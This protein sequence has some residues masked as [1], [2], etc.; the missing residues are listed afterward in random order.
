MAEKTKKFRLFDAVLTAVCV[1]LVVESSTPAAA[2]GNSQY[3]WWIVLLAAFFLP[4]GLVS[5]ELGTTYD[6]DGGIFDWVRRAFGNRWGSRIAWYYYINFS[7]WV[8]SLA[9]LFTDVITQISGYEMSVWVYLPI[10]LLFIWGVV[11]ISNFKISESKWIINS[12]AIIK[13]LIM[14]T[15][16]V[17]GIYVAIS[18]NGVNDFDPESFIPKFDAGGLSYISVI[19]FN[20]LGFEVVTSFASEMTQPSKQIPKALILGGLIIAFFYLLSAFGLSVAVPSEELSLSSGIIDG[21]MLLTGLDGGIIVVIFGILFLYTLIAN[22]ASW[23]YGVNYVAEYASKQNCLPAVLGSENKDGMPLGANVVNGIIA[24]AIVLVAPLLSGSD[25]FWSF[26][27]LNMVTLLLSYIV[28][29]PAFLKLRR[30]D[31]QRHRPFMVK[32]GKVTLWL[33]TYV[34]MIL[35]IAAVLFSII[36][37]NR[38][39]EEISAKLPLLIGTLVAIVIGEIIAAFSVSKIKKKERKNM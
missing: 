22:L 33:V 35:L 13:V 3:F 36:P 9:V 20:F 23:S 31:P 1:V 27:A 5:A 30:S 26:F 11:L 24:S 38:S 34:P 2:I 21:F 32:G 28:M 19:L 8:G 29:F 16:G 39:E 14:L 4:Y 18:G 15:I 37:L 12:A 7:L 25:V 17:F 6:D 10:Q